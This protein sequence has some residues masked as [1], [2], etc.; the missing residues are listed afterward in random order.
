MAA[1]SVY[2][3]INK[4][5]K[6]FSGVSSVFNRMRVGFGVLLVMALS[7]YA[8]W[9]V[10]A[11]AIPGKAGTA[12]IMMRAPNIVS[13]IDFSPRTP[14]VLAVGQQITIS[15]HYNTTSLTGVIVTAVPFTGAAATANASTCK[16][17][18]LPTG[19][20]LGTCTIRVSRGP[21]AVNS[22]HFQMWDSTHTTVLF[23]GVLP[24]NYQIGGGA[25]LVSGIS[26]SPSSPS[27]VAIGK[28]V[29]VKFN[30]STK[31]AGGVRIIAVPF[32][33]TVVTAN[34]VTCGSTVYPAGS[35]TGACRFSV[36][37]ANTAVNSIHIEVW[38]A[39]H[40]TML[41]QEVLPVAYAFRSGT[42]L[43]APVSV[44]QTPNIERLGDKLTIH[45]DYQANSAGGVIVTATPLS[46]LVPT[47][48]ATSIA[49]L[50]LPV[51][52]G[53]GSCSFMISNVAAHVTAVQ[54]RIWNSAKTT[55]L[56]SVMLPVNYQIQ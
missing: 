6:M 2:W 23:T 17:A 38:D 12:A 13:S 3:T 33:G 20:G 29:S 46:G 40:V 51:G 18:V 39:A 15:F 19:K 48:N 54:I 31:Q 43:L 49:S 22:I 8:P 24:V 21:V 47:A 34:S 1:E 50:L 53:K 52:A 28:G 56:F 30:Y 55:V 44:L 9:G 4:G 36:M 16:T 42:N 32:T 26:L 5:A 35:G 27:V 10:S 14:N 25:T 11:A 45:F 37:G 41:A 7:L